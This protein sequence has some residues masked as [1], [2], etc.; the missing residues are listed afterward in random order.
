MTRSTENHSQH[1]VSAE[2]TTAGQQ[3][4]NASLLP[5]GILLPL[6][7]RY[8]CVGFLS[9]VQPHFLDVRHFG[10]RDTLTHQAFT[11]SRDSLSKL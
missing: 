2:I 4:R 6:A 3:S 8:G 7:V 9:S 1:A 11:L 5:R 10:N